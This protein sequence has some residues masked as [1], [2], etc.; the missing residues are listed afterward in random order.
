MKRILLATTAVLTVTAAAARAETAVEQVIA[1]L[2]AQGFTDIEVTTGP[3]QVK[4]EASGGGRELEYVYDRFSGEV[5]M[6]EAGI[7]EDED[8]EAAAVEVEASDED[9]L[10]G[11]EEDEEEEE[12]DDPE[13]ESEDE[14][15]DRG[16]D[17]NRGHGDDEDGFDDE[18]PG[19]GHGDG[20]RGGGRGGDDEDDDAEDREE[21]EQEEREDREEEEDD[22]D[23][24]D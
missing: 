19:R 20:V 3:N 14:G 16:A 18:N 13:D 6:Q 5:L 22:E 10:D 23:D 7:D 21:D 4:V 17:G 12:E 2:Q 24:E 1:G 8:N 15:E 9:F 11:E